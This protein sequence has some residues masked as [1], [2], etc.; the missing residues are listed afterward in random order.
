[1]LE[2][3]AF[4]WPW[5]IFKLRSSVEK[6]KAGMVEWS[7]SNLVPSSQNT[8]VGIDFWTPLGSSEIFILKFS[9][10]VWYQNWKVDIG[11]IE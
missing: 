8:S 7:L 4:G 5:S 3:W 10:L 1:M 9:G 6:Q 11:C 2:S